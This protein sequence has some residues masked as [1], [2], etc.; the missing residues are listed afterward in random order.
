MRTFALAASGI[1]VLFAGACSE[2][3]GDTV[4]ETPVEGQ[5]TTGDTVVLE[6]SARE[7]SFVPDRL[8]MRPDQTAEIRVKS[9]GD[10]KHTLSIYEDDEYKQPIEDAGVPALNPGESQTFTFD[11]PPDIHEFY[12]RCE[13]H[14]EMTGEIEVGPDTAG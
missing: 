4:R 8:Q 2:N 12:F 14:N 9:E 10:A 1:A 5:T 11:P 6:V 13:I 3:T 7:F